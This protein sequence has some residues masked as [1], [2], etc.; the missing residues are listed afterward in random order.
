[1]ETEI[2]SLNERGDAYFNIPY[3][4]AARIILGRNDWD[5]FDERHF[6]NQQILMVMKKIKVDIDSEIESRYP[7]QRGSVVQI[8]LNRGILLRGKVSHPIGEPE[9][10][11]PPW[12]IKEK[13]RDAAGAFLSQKSMDRIERILGISGLADSAETLFEV[14]SENN[15]DR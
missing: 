8:D 9:N 1:V 11:L 5:S 10:P 15:M 4:L 14:L 3:A 12:I 2:D 7:N 13:F 6:S